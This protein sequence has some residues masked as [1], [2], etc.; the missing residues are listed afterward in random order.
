MYT[1]YKKLEGMKVMGELDPE[2]I[3]RPQKKGALRVINVIK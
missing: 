1:E 3:T 2:R